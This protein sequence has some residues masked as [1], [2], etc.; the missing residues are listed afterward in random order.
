MYI[1]CNG[2]IILT[3]D[4]GELLVL[5]YTTPVYGNFYELRLSADICWYSRGCIPIY[6]SSPTL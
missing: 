3:N 2:F 1:Y 4:L 5:L 6:K